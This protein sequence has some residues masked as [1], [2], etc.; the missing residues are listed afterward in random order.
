MADTYALAIE[1]LGPLV[2]RLSAAAS[3]LPERVTEAL[4]ASAY[5]S[6]TPVARA[7]IPHLPPAV[8]AA[9]DA[10]LADRSAALGAPGRDRWFRSAA[11][12]W[13]DIRQ[14][15]A[16]ASARW[17]ATTSPQATTVVLEARLWRDARPSMAMPCSRAC[18]AAG[19]AVAS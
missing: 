11:A 17:S 7:I 18:C 5:D 14:A 3:D 4:G 15:I 13:A 9:W 16:V 12:E 10:D 19:A 1:A 6:L 8:L 2:G